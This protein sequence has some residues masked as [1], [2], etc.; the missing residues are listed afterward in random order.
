MNNEHALPG[1]PDRK[2]VVIEPRIGAV[3]TI[4]F[5]NFTPLNDSLVGWLDSFLKARKEVKTVKY[6]TEGF[7]QAISEVAHGSGPADS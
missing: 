3:F 5:H 1:G 4:E 7:N 2:V 6:T